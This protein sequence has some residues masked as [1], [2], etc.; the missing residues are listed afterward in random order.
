M[1][2][3]L[4]DHMQKHDSPALSYVDLYRNHLEVL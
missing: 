2:L 4:F 1:K 3:G